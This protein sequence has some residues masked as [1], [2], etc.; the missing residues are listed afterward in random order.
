MFLKHRM[1]N[2][3][4]HKKSHIKLL[5]VAKKKHFLSILPLPVSD[6]F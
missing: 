6:F 3:Y 1:D 4:M 2:M 5:C